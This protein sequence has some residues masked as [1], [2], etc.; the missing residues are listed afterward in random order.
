M[1][2]IGQTV[3][4]GA[5]GVC[6]IEDLTVKRIGKEE[7]EYYVLKPVG[8]DS[9]TFFVPASNPVLVGK[10][11]EVLTPEQAREILSDLPEAEAWTES[12]LERTERFRNIVSRV[13]CR[14]LI[15]MIRTIRAHEQ[16]QIAKGK[17][18]H[19]SDERLLKEAE[20]MVCGELSLVL[21]ISGDE[22]LSRISQ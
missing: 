12:K 22:V 1:F 6:T 18:L 13:D 11:R 4:Y 10:I 16:L 17:R 21:Q 2:C 20:R 19:L 15:G 8:S 14:E 3:L 7:M 9:S 5:N